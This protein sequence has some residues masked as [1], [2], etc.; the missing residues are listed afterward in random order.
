MTN[1]APGMGGVERDPLT[2]HAHSM[3]GAASQVLL[4]NTIAM[5]VTAQTTGNTLVVS[6]TLENVGAGHHVPTDHPGRQMILMVGA[7]DK[8]GSPL[9]NQAGVMFLHGVARSL[10]CP[11]RLTPK[12]YAMP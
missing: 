11:A 1:V 3:P 10:V 2:I 8:D 4:Q 12:Y 6:V 7:V 5:S 9:T